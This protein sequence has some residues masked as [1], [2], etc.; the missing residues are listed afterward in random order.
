MTQNQIEH[1]K[2]SRAISRKELAQLLGISP[3]SVRRN[4]SKWGIRALR[5]DLNSR[6]VQYRLGATLKRLT[7]LGFIESTLA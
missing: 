6:C 2:A 1:L 3:R 5:C 4:E 7:D